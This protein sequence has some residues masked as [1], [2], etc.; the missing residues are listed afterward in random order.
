[1]LAEGARIMTYGSTGK[2]GF[3]HM[4]GEITV[5]VSKADGKFVVTSSYGRVEALG[6]V[7]GMTLIQGKTAGESETVELLVVD[8]EEGSVKVGN[9]EKTTVI[10]AG[11]RVTVEKNGAP[12]DFTQ[13]G[14]LPVRLIERIQAMVKAHEAGDSRAW[15]ENFNIQAFFDMAKGNIGPTNEQRRI[16]F[17]GMSDGDIERLRQNGSDVESP[18]QFLEKMLAAGAINLRPGKLYVC[19]VALGTEGRT[20]KAIC[21]MREGNMLHRNTPQW[22][23]FDDDW[24]Q[25]DD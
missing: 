18:E 11:Q 7:F 23:F 24:W 5:R 12:Y 19:S 8:V 17:P 4:A 1:M 14:S 16:M 15:A 22:G 6:T 21:T 2:R 10:K 20:A 9:A 13:D 3:E 25:T